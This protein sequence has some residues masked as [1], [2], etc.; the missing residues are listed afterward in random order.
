MEHKTNPQVPVQIVATRGPRTDTVNLE[1]RRDEVAIDAMTFHKDHA[2]NKHKFA[3]KAGVPVEVVE[4]KIAAVFATGGPPAGADATS[5]AATEFSLVLRGMNQPKASGKTITDNKPLVALKAALAVRDYPATEPV[6]EWEGT[7]VVACVDLDHHDRPLG[8]RPDVHQLRAIALSV[9]PQPALWW[10]THG[11]GL[12]LIYGADRGFRADELAACAA[13][14]LRSLEPAAAMEILPRSRHPAYPRP[15]YPPAGEVVEGTPTLDFGALSRWLG[16]EL[17]ADLIDNWLAEKGYRKDR[18]YAHDRCPVD[19]GSPS[20]DEPVF[21]NDGGIFCAKCQA[22]GI[23]LGGQKAGYFPYGALISGGIPSRL[24]GAARHRCHWAHA[25][26]IVAEDIGIT[27]PLAKRCY[28]ALLKVVN[29]SDDPRNEQAMFRGEGLIRMDGY[30]ATADLSR[31]HAKDG[32]LL[33]RLAKLPAVQFRTEDGLAGDE[34]RLGIFRGVDDLAPYGYPR[35]QPV[36]GMKVYWHFRAGEDPRVVRAVVLPEFLTEDAAYPYRPCYVPAAKR[37]NLDDAERVVSDSFP[38]VSHPYLRLLIAA[39]GCSEGG[40]GQPAMVAVDGPSGAGKSTTVAI[41]AALIGDKHVNV[42]WTANLEHY[43]QGLYEASTSAGLVTSDEIVKLSTARGGD[44][45]AG[46]N[47]LLTF[48]QGSLIRKLYTGPVSVRQVPAIILTDIVFPQVLLCDVQLG[49]RLVHVHLERK[50][51]WQ[52]TVKDINRWR[53]LRSEH[54]AAANAIVSNVIDRYFGGDTPLAFEDVAKDLGF[55]ML[56]QVGDIGLDPKDELLT[57][58]RLCCSDMAIAAP[59]KTWK[60]RGWRYVKRDGADPLSRHWQRVC[61][62]LQEGFVTSRRVKEADWAQLLGVNDAV[63]CDLTPNGKSA[64]GIRFRCGKS[65]AR[66]L[67]VNE[68][69]TVLPPD[70]SDPADPPADD[71]PADRPD[72]P[73]LPP[74][75]PPPPSPGG[76]A[77]DPLEGVAREE[78][79]AA[80]SDLHGPDGDLSLPPVFMDTETRSACDLTKVGGRIYARH[81]STEI[82]TV[83]ALIDR[84]IIAWAPLL[85]EPLPVGELWPDGFGHDRLPIAS[86]AGPNL[87]PP[88]AEAIAAGRP[89]CAHNA[90]GFDQFVWAAKKLPEPSAWLDTLPHVRAAGLPGQLDTLGERL[91]GR[92]KD[93][94]GAALLNRLCRPNNRGEFLPLNGPNATMLMRY[95]VGDVLLLARVFEAAYGH[96][97]LDVLALDNAINTRG[98]LFDDGLARSLIQLEINAAKD[99]GARVEQVTGGAVKARDLRGDKVVKRYLQTRGVSL[100]NLK[101]ET[102]QNLLNAGSLLDPVVRVVLEGRLAVNRVT[103]AKLQAAL[104][105]QDA[106]GRLRDTLV[107]HKALTGRW[108]SRGVQLHNL[109]RPHK[110]VKDVFSLVDLANDPE[111]FRSALPPTVNMADA[112]SAM[113]RPTIRAAPGNKLCLADFASIEARGV[114]WCAAALVNLSVADRTRLVAL[115]LAPPTT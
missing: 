83:V 106:D 15:G 71:P 96:A 57:L 79:K 61:D 3:Q 1:A 87:P 68:E 90:F 52:R 89:L 62:N 38:G 74:D 93:K 99:V 55:E 65:R 110:D 88:L 10:V 80:D 53:S 82:M 20:H 109:P 43:F 9:R 36:R 16:H 8:E 64:V 44:V 97:E 5:T 45:R 39:R 56:N 32:G 67:K 105:A 6:I 18:R 34:E 81:S 28:S 21:V 94:E 35:V 84:Q 73:Q 115:L 48:T 91:L 100:P 49:R 37:M 27:G 19:P 13:L 69:I 101:R 12:R 111:G 86:F 95:N 31:S 58:F 2:A 50:V 26:H 107:Y 76:A 59:D 23:T 102:V 30:W 51:D 113:I 17:D 46:L 77:I 114:A 98:V 25:Q 11:R 78:M 47:A 72:D 4:Q 42:P 22:T 66:D 108:S 112:I 40:R 29:G 54:A 70:S 85:T 75:V 24:R 104:V 60:G 33:A 92:G 14:S 103:T 41:A 7:A 63:E